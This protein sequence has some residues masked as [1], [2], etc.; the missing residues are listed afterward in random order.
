MERQEAPTC[1]AT[2]VDLE[3]ILLDE[4]SQ[5]QKCAQCVVPCPRNVPDRS[6]CSRNVD[7]WL[8]GAGRQDGMEDESEQALGFLL[9]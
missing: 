2:R 7:E 4:R 1:A 8:R 9:R 5:T 3:S 6:I